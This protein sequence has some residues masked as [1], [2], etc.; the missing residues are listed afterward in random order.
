MEM[1]QICGLGV[2]EIKLKCYKKQL[3]ETQKVKFC[4]F[5][6]KEAK[7]KHF[8]ALYNILIEETYGVSVKKDIQYIRSNNRLEEV[9]FTDEDYDIFYES[10][11]KLREILEK[12]IYPIDVA[13]SIRCQE[14]SYKNICSK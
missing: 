12:E 6:T 4:V 3:I 8:G 14:C 13:E 11:E 10:Y 2:R 7:Q 9:E 5:L 1:G